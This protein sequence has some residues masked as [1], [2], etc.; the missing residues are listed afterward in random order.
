MFGKREM[1]GKV[2]AV[3]VA[4]FPCKTKHLADVHNQEYKE[5]STPSGY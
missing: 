4:T 5:T 1:S 3:D 2:N